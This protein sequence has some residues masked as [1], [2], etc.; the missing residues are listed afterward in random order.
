M[1]ATGVPG[2]WSDPVG[3][4]REV[5]EVRAQL[6]DVLE[7]FGTLF[8]ILAG[9]AVQR[10]DAGL[11]ARISGAAEAAKQ[12]MGTPVSEIA[13]AR[14]AG[15]PV[16]PPA[17]L[18]P[19]EHDVVSRVAGGLTNRQIA[20]ELSIGVRTVDTH[21]TNVLVKLGVVSRAQIAVWA[22]ENGLSGT[23]P[24]MARNP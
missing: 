19:R 15:P 1:D 23:G 7:A 10:G 18:T 5:A 2:V 24:A 13:T 9:I 17:A 12:A 21:V 16:G 20:A 22:A 8:G 6:A 3:R 11:A 4:D 14:P